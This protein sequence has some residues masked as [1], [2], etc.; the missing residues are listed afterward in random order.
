MWNVTTSFWKHSVR[1]MS[2]NYVVRGKRAA[3]KDRQHP[4][5]LR[6]AAVLE[7][8]E[9]LVGLQKAAAVFPPVVAG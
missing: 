4:D 1:T 6:G 9:A 2:P 5:E 7:I 8:R 3:E